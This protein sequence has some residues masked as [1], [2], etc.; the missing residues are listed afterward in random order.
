MSEGTLDQPAARR[1]PAY[2]QAQEGSGKL[3]QTRTA[4]VM[5]RLMN[6]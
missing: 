5:L 6:W 1:P 3:A 2:E 4:K